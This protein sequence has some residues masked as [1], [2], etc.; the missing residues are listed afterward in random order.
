MSIM[1]NQI[2][3]NEEMLRIYFRINWS[4]N[5]I[6]FLKNFYFILTYV[7]ISSLLLSSENI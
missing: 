4:S 3:I 2:C 5:L 7:Y 6:I 1:F